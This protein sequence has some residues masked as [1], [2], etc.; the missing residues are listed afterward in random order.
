MDAKELRIG[1]LFYKNGIVVT[2]DGTSIVTIERHFDTSN[3]SYSPIP[4]T[5][6]WLERF[7]FE[8]VG[9]ELGGWWG[10]PSYP[11][12]GVTLSGRFSFSFINQTDDDFIDENI[13][14]KYVHTLQN[15]FY[16]LTGTELT[17]KQKE[18][19]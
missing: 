6:E 16:S 15:L 11:T 4:L 7:G 9:H 2:I 10:H 3:T 1:N 14:C 12:Y 17:I 18:N 8:K 19:V 13:S 5:S